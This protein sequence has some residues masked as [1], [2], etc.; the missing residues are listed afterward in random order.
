MAA[1]PELA[2]FL[3]HFSPGTT[4]E[5]MFARTHV[6]PQ[7]LVALEAALYKAWTDFA[8]L[9]PPPLAAWRGGHA[10]QADVWA[11]LQESSQPRYAASGPGAAPPAAADPAIHP[12]ALSPPR[13][14]AE[15][16]PAKTPGPRVGFS[17]THAPGHSAR[18]SDAGNVRADPVAEAGGGKARDPAFEAP[19]ELSQLLAR[20][21]QVRAGAGRAGSRSE[22][23]TPKL[24]FPACSCAKRG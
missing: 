12:P 22:P 11:E 17:S 5:D 16:L 23:D 21:D 6:C 20:R 13:A 18:V 24:S 19:G 8:R 10:L 9:S 2:E 3:L 14:E 7:L 15:L 1:S 4:A